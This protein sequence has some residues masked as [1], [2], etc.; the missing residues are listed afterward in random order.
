MGARAPSAFFVGDRYS[1]ADIALYAY[2]HVAHEG[3]FDLSDRPNVS[4]WLAR[5]ANQTGNI[6]ID[7]AMS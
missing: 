4:A 2:M 1:I 3:G 6:A 7:D 5:V